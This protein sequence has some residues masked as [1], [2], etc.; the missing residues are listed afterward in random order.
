MIRPGANSWQLQTATGHERAQSPE[1]AQDMKGHRKTQARAEAS[2]Q[3]IDDRE[4]F[5]KAFFSIRKQLERKEHMN[6]NP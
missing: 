2:A 6:A 1:T 4:P 5:H 3:H